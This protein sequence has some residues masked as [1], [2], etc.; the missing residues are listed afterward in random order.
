[1]SVCFVLCDNEM[2][3][4]YDFWK[5]FIRENLKKIVFTA[6]LVLFSFNPRVCKA[7]ELG[8]SCFHG[9]FVLSLRYILEKFRLRIERL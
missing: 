5:I 7:V 4:L 2:F 6:G 8:M 3:G 9:R 1:M